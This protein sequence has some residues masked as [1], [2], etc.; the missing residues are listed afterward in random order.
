MKDR[1]DQFDEDNRMGES[2]AYTLA[3]R[4]IFK[5]MQKKLQGQSQQMQKAG[6]Q[7]TTRI[8]S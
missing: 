1:C 5:G 2:A 7:M 8:I 3:M 6:H 4:K